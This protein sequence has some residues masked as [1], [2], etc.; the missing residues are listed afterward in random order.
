[1][2]ESFVGWDI[3]VYSAYS[4]WFSLAGG[5]PTELNSPYIGGLPILSIYL[6]VGRQSEVMKPYKQ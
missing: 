6:F 5:V 4:E 1:M 2:P 3:R